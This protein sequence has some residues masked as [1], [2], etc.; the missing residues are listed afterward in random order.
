MAIKLKNSRR[1]AGLLAGIVLL[2][3]SFAM[4]SSYPVFAD[5]ME[6]E[7][8]G[9]FAAG[10]MEDSMDELLRGGYYLY[11]EVNENLEL[12]EVMQRFGSDNFFLM[13]KYMDYEVFLKDAKDSDAE[14]G[15]LGR[16]SPADTKKL[17]EQ[18]TDYGLRIVLEY[19]QNRNLN[20]V[21]V[22]GTCTSE[23]ERYRL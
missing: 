19:D 2:F 6:P 22:D 20:N 18:N 9:D 17:L 21:E 10:I 4:I 23:D 16:G 13:R 12:N 7:L 1:F 3:L 11:N 14:K 8:K 5:L 15:L